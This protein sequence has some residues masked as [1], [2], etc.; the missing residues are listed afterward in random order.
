MSKV[1]ILYYS[2]HGHVSTLAKEVARGA[3]S[4]SGVEVTLKRVPEVMTEAALVQAGAVSEADVP[5]ATVGELC[6][7][8]AI[9]FGTPT[10]FG[11]MASQMRSFLDQTGGLW[12]S[13][14]LVGKVGSVFVSTATGSGNETT[15]TSFHTT[16]FH[17]GMIVVGVPYTVDALS[18]VSVPRGGSV[19]G[20]GFLSGADG[21]RGASECELAIA[22]GQGRH[23][24]EVTRRLVMGTEEE[25]KHD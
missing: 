18:D 12:Y 21:R 17:H 10:R 6:H 14:A 2:M 23:V 20:A 19:L 1:L 11:N 13:R 24:A 5:V 7:Y 9:I 16:L 8:D 25:G 3:S 15:I 22:F 4:L